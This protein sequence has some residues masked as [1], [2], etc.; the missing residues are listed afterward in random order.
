MVVWSR[1]V[2]RQFLDRNH[3]LRSAMLSV[4]GLDLVHKLVELRQKLKGETD[5]STA[6]AGLV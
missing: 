1:S 6:S 4:I 5:P 3:D 2:F